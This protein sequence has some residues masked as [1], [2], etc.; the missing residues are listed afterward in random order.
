MLRAFI[1]GILHLLADLYHICSYESLGL[2]TGPDPGITNWN[3]NKKGKLL[4]Y[5]PGS[6]RV[7]IFG[8]Y[9]LLK[10]LYQVCSYDAAACTWVKTDPAL[11]VTIWKKTGKV[12]NSSQKL[13]S[14]ELGQAWTSALATAI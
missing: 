10:D 6:H 2:K 1:F 7:F 5:L 9:R 4:Y 11:A 14:I 12:Q 13:E 3:R 8:L